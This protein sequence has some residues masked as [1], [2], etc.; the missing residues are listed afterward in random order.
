MEP[1]R[2]A[3][4]VWRHF[5]RY[6]DTIG[7]AILYYKFDAE[8]TVYDRV[9]DEAFRKYLPGVRIP[10]LWVDQMEAVEDYTPEGRRPTERMRCAVSARSMYEAGISVVEVHGN[11]WTDTSS[12]D[13]WR[14][15]GCT[16]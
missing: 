13:I 6:H 14:S 11:Q 4:A 7:E 8:D 16:T 2:E 5:S 12:S 3:V 1:R 9:Y 10:I 15:D